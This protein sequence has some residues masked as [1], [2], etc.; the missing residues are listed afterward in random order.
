MKTLI[1]IRHAKSSWN[2]PGMGDFER[3]LNARGKSDAPLMGQ[4][5][6]MRLAANQQKLDALLCSSAQR[7]QETAHFLAPELDFA[8]TSIDWRKDLYLA[9]P[10]T[11][12]AVIKTLP[13]TVNTVALVAH[14]PG[15]TELAE[16]MTGGYFGDV[17][18]CSIITLTLPVDHW[19]DAANIADVLDYDYPKR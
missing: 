2:M 1:L 13:D 3:C 19:S 9:S 5:L 4:R 15:I 6:S 18:T 10:K 17:P 12:M 14:N 16:H 7:A 11:M 8:M